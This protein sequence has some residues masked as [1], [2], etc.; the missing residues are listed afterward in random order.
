MVKVIQTNSTVLDIINEISKAINQILELN[1]FAN[2]QI[3]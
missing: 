3:R 1:F 2:Q